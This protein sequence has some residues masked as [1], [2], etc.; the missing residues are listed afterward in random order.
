MGYQGAHARRS[1]AGVWL[2]GALLVGAAT[3]A[4]VGR[5][6][7]EATSAPGSPAPASA[8]PTRAASVPVGNEPGRRAPDLEVPLAGGGRFRLSSELGRPIVIDFLAPGCIDCAGEVRTLTRMQEAFGDD[9]VAVLVVD[10]A[11]VTAERARSYYR[12]L[13]GGD[14]LY[15]EDVGF[16][17]ARAYD[18]IALSTT[19]VVDPGG[20][21]VYRDDGPTP[22]ELL[23]AAIRRALP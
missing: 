16:H 15:G 11:G 23:R 6:G 9:G 22:P 1:R 20:V 19:F 13:G 3:A 10:V 5:G 18:V 8:V 17:A 4:L 2:T 7:S 12:S 21:I 14:L